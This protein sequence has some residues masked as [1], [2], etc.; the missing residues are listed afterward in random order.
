MTRRDLLHVGSLGIAGLGLPGIIPG[1]SLGAEGAPAGKP[2]A[3]ALNG[4][5]KAKACI[6]L[7]LYGSPSQIETFDPKPDAPEGIRGE[8]QSIASCV[9]GLD[10]C[11]RLP[12][13]AQV[14]DKVTVVRS[15]SHPFPLHGVAFATTGV[16]AIT[17][18]M[19]LNPRD[20]AHWPFIGS[21][22]DYVDTTRAAAQAQPRGGAS[23]TWCSPGR[24]RPAAWVRSPA[25]GRMVGSWARPGI[26]LAPSSSAREREPPGRP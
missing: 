12:R 10:V 3:A 4:F 18:P 26:R 11:E 25:P 22:V 21:V 24:S 13:M 14:M 7:F 19:E 16:S 17:A 2:V 5:G 6:L 1:M 23:A 15:V 9:P 20:P 8:F